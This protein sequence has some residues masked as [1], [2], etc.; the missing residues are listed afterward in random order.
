MTNG[1]L[2]AVV[3]TEYSTGTGF[4]LDKFEIAGNSLFTTETSIEGGP[5]P[6]GLKLEFA[7]NN[8]EKGE[9]SGTFKNDV[10]TADG[11]FDVVGLKDA[12]ISLCSGA[13]GATFGA[14]ADVDIGGASVSDYSIGVAYTVPKTAAVG[15]M[16]TKKLAQS[17]LTL[18][19]TVSPDINVA[20]QLTYKGKVT[21][22]KV[23]GSYIC[24]PDTTIKVKADTGGMVA[25]SVKQVLAPKTTAV[26]KCSF[27]VSKPEPV[28]GGSLTLG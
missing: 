26:F 12:S 19:Y 15:L 8:Q 17:D 27:K 21:D 3:G 18:G 22:F 7:G 9:I 25:T 13:S 11:S 20:A 23:G 5:L 6:S 14:S 4:N 10:V 1:A 28:F 16:M 2:S 24:N